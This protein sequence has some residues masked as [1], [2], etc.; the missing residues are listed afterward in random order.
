MLS[1]RRAIGA[2]RDSCRWG[3]LSSAQFMTG[4]PFFVLMVILICSH[5]A[6]LCSGDS[7]GLSNHGVGP[8]HLRYRF[9]SKNQL[10]RWIKSG[11]QK[12]M[13]FYLW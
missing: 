12:N 10:D 8:D 1:G 5:C 4:Y 13:A 11:V 3:S 9:V 6:C 7:R 2:R